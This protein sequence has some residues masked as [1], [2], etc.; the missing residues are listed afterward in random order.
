MSQLKNQH[1]EYFYRYQNTLI[2]LDNSCVLKDEKLMN[3]GHFYGYDNIKGED[4]FFEIR[5]PFLRESVISNS[6]KSFNRIRQLVV[7]LA[8]FHGVSLITSL[9]T[10]LSTFYKRK[11]VLLLED[12]SM[13]ASIFK[14][15]SKRYGIELYTSEFLN[16]EMNSG[17]IVNGT[18]HI[19]IQET[20]FPDDFFDLIVHTEVFEHVPDAIKGEEE[21][22]RILKRGGCAIFTAP[23]EYNRT[24]DNVYAEIINNDIRYLQEPMYHADPVSAD[25]KCL[26]FRTFSLPEM[27]GRFADNGC[28]FHCEYFHSY[29]LGILGNNAFTFIAKKN[30]S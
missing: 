29:Y 30:D 8:S 3:Q 28:S 5:S 14:H 24:T 2:N 23:F 11:R 20:H 10:L 13:F 26:V 4:A 27:A 19:D 15:Y 1:F 21:I 6:S 9:E 7:S 25:G 17:E 18:M 22:V 12:V 16:E